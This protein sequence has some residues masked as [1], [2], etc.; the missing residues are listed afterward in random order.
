M[1][2]PDGGPFELPDDGLIPT[3]RAVVDL[4]RVCNAKCRMCY[5]AHSGERWSKGF[6]EVA[7]ELQAARARGCTSVDFT[8]GE[9][10]LHPELPRIIA[11]AEDLGLHTC[12]ITAG[13]ALA[14]IKRAV[15]AGCREWLV[16]M[17]GFEARHDAIVGAPGAWGK[18]NDAVE[19][20]N[21]EGC[22]VRVNCTLTKMNAADLPMLARHYVDAVRARVV[23]FIN[24]NPHG[25]WSDEADPAVARGLDEVQIG[26]SEVAPPLREALNHL[27]AQGVWANVRYF[28][29]CALRGLESHVC[30]NPQVMF[31]P[32]EWDYG[33]APKTTAAYLA[34]GRHF[35]KIV[36]SGEGPCTSCGVRD[37]C[38]GVNASYARRRG[39][40]ELTAYEE[41]SE[42]PYYFRSDLEAD[43]VVPAY[44]LSEALGR[45]LAEIPRVTAPPY[46][47]VVVGKHQSA[48]RNRN[49]G[50]AR[51]K[52]PYVIMC[53][54]DIA[55][56]PY[57]WNRQLIYTLKENRELAAVSARLMRPDGSPGANTA[58]DTCLERPLVSVAHIPTACCIFRRTEVRFDE[59]FERAG[60]E[61]TDYFMQLRKEHGGTVAISNLVKVVHLN[62]EKNG[63]GAGNERN[64]ALFRAKWGGGE[65]SVDPVALR[66]RAAAQLESGDFA[67]AL[68]SLVR[69]AGTGEADG[70]TF[71]QL[72][73]ASWNLGAREEALHYFERAAAL[74][75]GDGDALSNFFDAA[76][77][78]G[79]FET[80]ERFLRSHPGEGVA[81]LPQVYLLADCL[82]RQGRRDEARQALDEIIASAP[83]YPGVRELRRRMDA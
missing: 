36:G 38:G 54:D 10:T 52:S 48:A 66:A 7:R 34:H 15:A 79:R 67:G 11:L 3:A 9:P 8:G 28:P 12:V 82:A 26:I 37:V 74:S 6:E 70:A 22:F 25:R 18:V 2:T 31:D 83:D 58:N 71:N 35:Q 23:N 50:L 53:D 77:S 76:Y 1:T 72:G 13:L 27:D 14:K 30:N 40:G 75:P 16:S 24:F 61:D 43:I 44:A 65:V 45:L 63:G 20:L 41:M 49:A 39:F 32:Y 73:F 62:E 47:L 17:H 57:G 56:L 19:Y 42:Y 69:V 68:E 55:G 64:R 4:N 21:A 51:A 33:V 81:R 60:W 5:H 80:V 59:R 78:L 29:L 46:N